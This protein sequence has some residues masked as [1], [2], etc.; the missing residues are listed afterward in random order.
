MKYDNDL[1]QV[2]RVYFEQNLDFG[3]VKKIFLSLDFEGL[4]KAQNHAQ[5]L[6]ELQDN[7]SSDRKFK[8]ESFYE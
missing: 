8:V 2:F 7:Q 4:T 6:N 5:F 3:V 1:K